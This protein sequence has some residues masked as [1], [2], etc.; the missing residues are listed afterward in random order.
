MRK[1]LKAQI[2]LVL[3]TA[4]WGLG[5]PL[6]SLALGGIGPYTLVSVRSLLA[7]LM[8]IIIFRKRISIINWKTIK[9]GVLIAIALMVGS[10]LQT[11]GMLYTTPSKSSFITGFSVIFV[12]I[13][14]III[15]KKPPTRRM[16]MSIV[17]S[18]IGLILM[19][20]NGDAG[21]NIGD[22]L[23]LLCAL[24]FSVQMLLV[25]KFGSSFDGI[26][27]AMVELI[28]MSILATPVAFLQE[29]YHIDYTSTSV[30]LCILV[31]GLLGSGF[32]MVMQNK[33]QPLINPAHA[34]VIYLCEPVFGVFFSLFIGDMLSLRAGIGAVLILI[35]MFIGGQEQG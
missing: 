31:T 10:F 8:L 29:G 13:F 5:F 18:I 27:L 21:I 4:I 16:V 25:D 35:A 28:T 2:I 22:I 19:T 23:T 9:A 12:P 30:I 3:L 15:Y 34:A 14:M 33:M 20:Y 7:S 1:E 17:I 24:V 32:A 11:G 26:T 6:T